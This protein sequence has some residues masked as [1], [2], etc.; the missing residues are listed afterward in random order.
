MMGAMRFVLV[1]HAQSGNNQIFA[2]TGGEEGRHPDT[3]L[4]P[5]GEEQAAALAAY[6]SSPGLPWR[7]THL[8]CSLMTRAIQTAAPLADALDLPLVADPELYEC[9]GPHDYRHGTR[10]RIPHP[11]SP[12]SA[13]AG[14]SPRIVL[15]DVATE[16]G[17]YTGTLEDTQERYAARAARVVASLRATLPEDTTVGLVTHGWFTEYLLRELLEI[18][19]LGGWFSLRNTSVSLLAENPPGRE[20]EAVQIGWLPHLAPDQVTE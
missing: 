6:A 12:R 5:H 4:T 19:D 18:P 13:L 11:G 10:E 8:R 20:V 1:R 17:W 3:P 9:M 2:S 16:D 7:I 14:L 15:P